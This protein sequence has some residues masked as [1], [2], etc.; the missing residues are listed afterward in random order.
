MGIPSSTPYILVISEQTLI[1]GMCKSTSSHVFWPL[2]THISAHRSETIWDN[3]S[4]QTLSWLTVG[5]A[6]H[7]WWTV[8]SA[9]SA[10]AFLRC[11]SSDC[12]P[13]GCFGRS[14][15]CQS[16]YYCCCFLRGTHK[17]HR[18]IYLKHIFMYEKETIKSKMYRCASKFRYQ[19]WVQIF[20]TTLVCFSPLS[21]C[22]VNTW[23]L[24]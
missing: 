13:S 24:S 5:P 21:P 2:D 18:V 8:H 11:C 12:W 10:W 19:S 7:T 16:N 6:V 4:L 9:P 1:F 20:P 14:P 22:S 3:L 15:H 23:T 17:Q